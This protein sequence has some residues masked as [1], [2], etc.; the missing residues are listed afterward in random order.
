LVGRSKKGKEVYR[1]ASAAGSRIPIFEGGRKA[2]STRAGLP[3]AVVAVHP[4]SVESE[5]PSKTR[6][7]VKK[8]GRKSGKEPA[9]PVKLQMDEDHEMEGAPGKANGEQSE[10]DFAK[11]I[12]YS[13]YEAGFHIV[14]FSIPVSRVN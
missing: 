9:S 3:P 1:K 12:L 13:L 7:K 8:L 2:S 5:S 4:L 11:M 14:R 10:R 6:A